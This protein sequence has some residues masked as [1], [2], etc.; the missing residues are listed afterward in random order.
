MAGKSQF[1]FNFLKHRLELIDHPPQYILYLYGENQ[2]LFTQMAIEIPDIQFIEGV[3][4]DLDNLID[5][6]RSGLMVLDDLITE[7]S[8]AK[9]LTNLFVKGSHHKNLNVVL[10]SQNLFQQGREMRTI[11]LDNTT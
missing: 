1:V 2:P 4:E 7:V 5:P 6:S 10:I 3:P 9:W 8:D 11:G